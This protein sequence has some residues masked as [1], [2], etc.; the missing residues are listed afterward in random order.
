MPK[1][2]ENIRNGLLN[3]RIQK[4]GYKNFPRPKH[5]E[6]SMSKEISVAPTLAKSKN[7]YF[8]MES[9]GKCIV[10]A[11]LLL[12]SR[13]TKPHVLTSICIVFGRIFLSVIQID[14]KMKNYTS[15]PY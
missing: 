2:D 4:E 14:V 7:K 9:K 1:P 12:L 6:D 5:A 10:K 11:G 3:Q 8:D 13:Q 15:L